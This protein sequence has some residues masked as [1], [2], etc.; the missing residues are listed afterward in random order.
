MAFNALTAWTAAPDR[1]DSARTI[2]FATIAAFPHPQVRSC[3]RVTPVVGHEAAPVNEFADLVTATSVSVR[4]LSRRHP[5]LFGFEPKAGLLQHH[6]L[7]G[8]VPLLGYHPP[9]L[10][11]LQVA[12]LDVNH[13][14][15]VD[16]AAV[17]FT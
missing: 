7:D 1:V 4:L 17:A 15:A 11:R 3:C 2:H 6:I 14:F 10:Q 9:T 8:G 13:G 12:D 5:L 16:D